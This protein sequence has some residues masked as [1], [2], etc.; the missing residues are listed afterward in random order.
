VKKAKILDSYAI[1]SLLQNE[2]GADKVSELLEKAS[3][4]EEKLY[5]NWINVGEVYYQIIRREGKKMADETLTELQ[6]LPITFV[7][8]TDEL[9][10]SAAAEKAKY[11]IAFSD[12]FVIATAKEKR[13]VIVT[14]DP[15]FKAIEAEIKVEWI[16]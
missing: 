5:M 10:L 6:L 16:D 3:K 11:P 7:S 4:G 12:C 14:G 1:L 8:V 13:A 9:V 2:P 15:E